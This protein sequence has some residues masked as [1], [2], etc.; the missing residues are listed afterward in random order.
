MLYE[1]PARSIDTLMDEIARE[2]PQVQLSDEYG[3]E[4]M[5][6]TVEDPERVAFI[7]Q[8]M[9]DK[10]LIIADGHHRYETAIAYRDEMRGEQG[11]DC[12]PMC[13]F[14]MDGPGLSIL[15]THRVVSNL[16]RFDPKVF[17][18]RASEWFDRGEGDGVTIGVF[19]DGQLSRLR[20]KKSVDLAALMPDL[21]QKQRSLD[22]VILHRLIV[23]KCLGVTE[24]AVR[25][26]SHITYVRERDAAI[27][28]VRLGKAQIAF[29]LN[30]TRLDQLRDIAFEGNVMPQKSTD[31]YPKVLSGLTMY[32]MERGESRW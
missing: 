26:E 3:V 18:E 28:A 19:T 23:E 21:S 8:Q 9:A 5:M 6:W 17:F 22:V 16:P 27:E 14:N 10:K 15:P 11:S 31:F 13:F 12:I 29:L 24:D 2:K 32:A 7:Q 30:A 1:D 20:L 25:K 4:H